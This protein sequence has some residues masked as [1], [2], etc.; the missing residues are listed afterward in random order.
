[1][2]HSNA[3][4]FELEHLN[5][6]VLDCINDTWIEFFVIIKHNYTQKLFRFFVKKV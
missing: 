5:L 6:I 3:S 4:T 2:L 1:M